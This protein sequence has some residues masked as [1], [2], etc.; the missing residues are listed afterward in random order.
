MFGGEFLRP[1]RKRLLTRLRPAP[2]QLDRDAQC[3]FLS[4]CLLARTAYGLIPA[5]PQLGRN[6]D[7]VGAAWGVVERVHRRPGPH[8]GCLRSLPIWRVKRRE[9][10]CRRVPEYIYI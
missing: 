1:S 2:T 10:L 8:H 6:E 4:L 9:D 5:W 3:C 7:R